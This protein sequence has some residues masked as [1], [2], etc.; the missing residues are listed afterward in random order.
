M[1]RRKHSI[2]KVQYYPWFPA[3]P[4][5][6][7]RCPPWIRGDWRTAELTRRD[8]QGCIM[9]M[10]A[11]EVPVPSCPSLR[12]P[13]PHAVR[14]HKQDGEAHTQR[15]QGHHPD[16]A[17]PQPTATAGLASRGAAICK[18]PRSSSSS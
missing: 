10:P 2:Y 8:F 13:S 18:Q 3:S 15:Q 14:K 11:L 7:R 17:K 9:K 4:G 5:G 16:P 12:E 1:Y 6:L